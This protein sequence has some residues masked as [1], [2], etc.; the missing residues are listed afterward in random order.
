MNRPAKDVTAGAGRARARGTS[1]G[2]A[3]LAVEDERTARAV[4]SRLTEPGDV[5][6]HRLVGALGA[7]A[8]LQAVLQGDDPRV[9]AR[10][11]VRLP[12]GDVR[13]DL[14]RLADLGGHLIVPGDDQWPTALDDLDD[15]AP[16]CL[17]ARGP[18]ELGPAAERSV[19]LVGARAAS[20]YGEHVANELAFGLAERGFTVVSGAAYGIDAGAHRA[21]LAATG[22]T[23]AVLACGVDR[24]YPR[25][26]HRLIERIAVQGCVVSEIPPGCSPTRW[27][28]VQRN[29]LIAALALGTVVVEAALRSGTSITAREAGDLGRPVGAV[30]GPVTSP[31][32]SGCH[33]LLRLGAVCVTCVDE[34]VELVSALGEGLAGRPRTP[35]ADHD[36]LAPDDL[37]VLDAVPLRRAAPAGTVARTAGLEPSRVAATLALLEVRGLVRPDGAGWVRAG[38]DAAT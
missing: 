3:G 10:W 23:V 8:A 19:A 27:R 12:D 7:E 37:R 38:G 24:P 14:D 9:E 31:T 18:L 28:F 20:S 6:A 36:G 21:A 33:E 5:A 17:W 15:R 35:A 16:F 22:A 32:S 34:V 13:R 2:P 1:L 25:G 11:R 29:R 4:W 30:P 26:N